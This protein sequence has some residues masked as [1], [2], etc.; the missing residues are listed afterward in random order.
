MPI[1]QQQIAAAKRNQD[2]AAH[3][4]NSPIRLIAGP[5]T[6]KSFTIQ[7]R[8]S[9]LLKQGVPPE[10]IFVLSFTRA[11][12]LDLRQR[13]Q[14]YCRDQGCVNPEAV[15]V[16]TLHSMALRALR[17]ARLLAYPASPAILDDWEVNKIFDMEFSKY[18]EGGSTRQRYTPGRCQDIR[19]DYEAYCGTGQWSPP[20]LIPPNPPINPTERGDYHNFHISR[21]QVYSC[22]LPGEIVRQC[23]EQMRAGIFDPVNMLGITHLIVDEY[24]DLNPTDLEFIDLMINQGVNVFVAGDDDQSIYSFRFA[25]PQ[26]IQLFS[27]RFPHATSYEIAE[28]FR[29]TPNILNSAQKLI[30]AFSEPNRLPKQ[31]TSLYANASPPEMGI[32]HSWR[33]RSG[34]REA[35]AIAQSCAELISQG[36]ALKD[37]MIL[38][39]NTR[40]QLKQITDELDAIPLAYESPRAEAFTDTREGRF[41]LGLLR[42]VCNNDDYLAHRLILGLYPNVGPTIC[43]HIAELVTSNNLNF[44]DLFYSPLPFGV[45]NGGELRAL[46]NARGICNS[47]IGWI[48]TDTLQQRLNEFESI[49][50]N[51]FG[52]NTLQKWHDCIAG[53]PQGINLE[54]LRDYLWADNSEQVT[55][56]LETI[57]SRLNIAPP[58]AGFNTPRIRIM[59]FHGAKGLSAKV[60]FIPGL[61]ENI[62]PGVK[63]IPYNGLVLEAARMLYV[64]IAR[65][66]A[67]CILSYAEYRFVNGANTIQAHSRFNSHLNCRFIDRSTGLTRQEANVIIQICGN[68]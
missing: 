62:L 51:V 42:I 12:A 9:W 61:E 19:L 57:Y 66:I 18:S 8:V 1:T 31:T 2:V 33:F 65:S 10:D 17:T 59:T 58:A 3:D 39:S 49:V 41:L 30:T 23:V 11:S 21:T 46:N 37:I 60:V 14:K 50:E 47:I 45:F 36:C 53:L 5:G 16:T 64:A 32:I 4:G 27:Q 20:S 52:P 63:R 13:I 43:N 34:V 26:G 29:C 15:S 24:Q 54:E 38:I 22:V 28:C 6:G 68:L 25:S 7:K 40:S 67:A 35:R 55:T 48:S 44:K 56:L